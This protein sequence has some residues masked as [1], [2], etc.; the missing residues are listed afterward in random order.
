MNTDTF[1]GE[2]LKVQLIEQDMTQ[3]ELAVRIGVQPPQVSRLISG[4]REATPETLIKIA[5][6]LR[7][8]R[9]Q[10]F[11]A[12]GL[13]PP[14]PDANKMIEKILHEVQDMPEIDQQE[15]LAFIRMKNNLRKQRE[16]K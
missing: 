8:S 3:S 16:R 12:A 2:W 9:Q 7:M 5:D 6:A 11:R 1:F 4:E 15:V 10:V 13:L 14:D